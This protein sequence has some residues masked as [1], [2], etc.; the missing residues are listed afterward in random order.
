MLCAEQHP[1][2]QEHRAAVKKYVAAIRALVALVD[3]S[4]DTRRRWMAIGRNRDRCAHVAGPD[5]APRGG[6]GGLCRYRGYV[7]VPWGQAPAAAQTAT[8]HGAARLVATDDTD[9][10]SFPSGHSTTAFAVTL[11]LGCFYPEIMA[12]L[13][14]LA[15]NVAISRVVSGMH[16]LSDVVAGSYI[17]TLLG[18]ATFRLASLH[19]ATLHFAFSQ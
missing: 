5:A 15:A 9:Q 16:F 14:V 13:I 18:Y 12:V 11:S 8:R 10:F 1:F 2:W 19:F 7:D 4:D 17:E 3:H 6:V